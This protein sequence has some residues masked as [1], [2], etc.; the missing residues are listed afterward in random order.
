VLLKHLVTS[1]GKISDGFKRFF[2]D[3]YRGCLNFGFL[4]GIAKRALLDFGKQ[5]IFLL[6][7]LIWK[8]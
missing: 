6:K 1:H 8:R 5:Q 4:K 3:I 7:Q 2:F